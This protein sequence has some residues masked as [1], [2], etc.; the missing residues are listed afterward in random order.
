MV[1]GRCRASA[2][3]C[4]AGRADKRTASLAA[5]RE[6]EAKVREE[7]KPLTR[8]QVRRQRVDAALDLLEQR[9][10]ALVV[11]RQRPAQQRVEDHAARPHVDLGPCVELAADDLGRRIVR[12]PA[13]RLE[14]VAVAHEVAQAKVGDLDG[15]AVAAVEQQVLGLEV[16]ALFEWRLFFWSGA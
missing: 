2:Q 7:E 9:R 14:E 3:V 12:R 11:K 8:R 6:R 4:D 1:R 5:E 16:A 15:E 13:R 10:D